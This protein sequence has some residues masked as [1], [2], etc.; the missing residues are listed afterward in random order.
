MTEDEYEEL[1][2]GRIGPSHPVL[3]KKKTLEHWQ[4][5][6]PRLVEDT[7]S[8]L[9]EAEAVIYGDREATYGSP[10]KNLQLI[11]N[12]WGPILGQTITVDQVCILM[13]LLKAARLLNQPAHRDSQ[14]DICGYAALMERVQRFRKGNQETSISEQINQAFRK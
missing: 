8:I 14:V 13:I 5:A 7:K 1:N 2:Q 4:S 3:D 9:A 12:L 6:A 10:D 11:A